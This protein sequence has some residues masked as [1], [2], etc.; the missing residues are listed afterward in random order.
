M[1]QQNEKLTIDQKIEVARM[2][3]G[4]FVRICPTDLIKQQSIDYLSALMA[5]G[6]ADSASK[7]LVKMQALFNYTFSLVESAIIGPIESAS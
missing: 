6:K 3:T 5:N 7:E 2:A 4:I 1:T